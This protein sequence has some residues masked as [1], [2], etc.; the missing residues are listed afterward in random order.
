MAPRDRLS[1]NILFIW[2]NLCTAGNG[3][4]FI[5]FED[6][7]RVWELASKFHIPSGCLINKADI[8][9]AVTDRIKAFMHAR[10]WKFW[11][12]YPMTRIFLGDNQGVCLAE[13]NPA[14]WKPRFTSIWNKIK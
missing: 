14:K 10:G 12:R 1:G 2:G 8:N 11:M 7:K 6:L 4:Q 3:I 9:P 5:G 13:Y